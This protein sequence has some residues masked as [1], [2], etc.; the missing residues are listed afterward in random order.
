M[1]PIS[2]I[3]SL[4]VGPCRVM[5]PLQLAIN[6]GT[7]NSTKLYTTR[8]HMS[9]VMHKDLGSGTK[10]GRQLTRALWAHNFVILA[11]HMEGLWSAIA[12]ALLKVFCT[13]GISRW[14]ATDKNSPLELPRFERRSGRYQCTK[15]CTLGKSKNTVKASNL[16]VTSL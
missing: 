7:E 5:P 2:S 14:E 9:F 10:Q 12:S 4:D 8:D 13:Q 1:N 11:N 6:K 16:K 15:G 3:Q